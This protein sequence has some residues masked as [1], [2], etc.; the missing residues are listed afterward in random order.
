MIWFFGTLALFLSILS[1]IIFFG[2]PHIKNKRR[3]I[4]R[5][6][7][8]PRFNISQMD[9]DHYISEMNILTKTANLM[10]KICYGIWIS[11]IWSIL[12]FGLL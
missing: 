3:E 9:A 10:E 8:M 11:L 1:V 5:E 7:I 12:V 2:L 6:Y 4:I